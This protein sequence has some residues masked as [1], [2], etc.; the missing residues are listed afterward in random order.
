ML[1]LVMVSTAALVVVIMLVMVSTAAL[2]VMLMLVMVSTAALVVM[3]VFPAVFSMTLSVSGPDLSPGF[4]RPGNPDQLRNQRI[5]IFRRQPQLLCGKGDD[6]FLH[7]L[8]IVEFLLNLGRT[9]GAVQIF[10]QIYFS[11]H[12]FP[13]R[14]IL[15]YEHSF[16]C[17]QY[18]ALFIPCQQKKRKP[19]TIGSGFQNQLNMGLIFWRKM[20]VKKK[21]VAA[22]LATS[23]MG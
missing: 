12:R 16:I 22:P 21:R 18:T 4:H 17:F 13:S 14:L 2:V 20:R 8:M 3:M 7:I 19:G 11:G 6:S 23:A 15:T 1:M 5:G 9:V 10:N